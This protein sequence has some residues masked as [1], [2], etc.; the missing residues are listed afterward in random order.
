MTDPLDVL[1]EPDGPVAPDP[2]FAARLRARL[3]RALELP[4]GVRVSVATTDVRTPAGDQLTAA[5]A[6]PAAAGAA[7]PYLAVADARRAI[8]WYVDV[9]GAVAAGDPIVMPDGRIGHAELALAGGKLYLAD[10]YPEIGVVAPTPD[11]AAVSLVLDR[12]RRRCPGGRRD[13]RRRRS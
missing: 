9:F 13:G 2:A 8:A 4:R 12:R 10:E 1:R 6:V 7:I 5:A 3:E 11:E